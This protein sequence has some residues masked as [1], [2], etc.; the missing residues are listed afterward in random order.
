MAPA[1]VADVLTE[2][3]VQGPV[4]SD[5]DAFL[6]FRDGYSIDVWDPGSDDTSRV[7][8]QEDIIAHT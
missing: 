1:V 3:I 4:D 2:D 7:G 5:M 6:I 8:A